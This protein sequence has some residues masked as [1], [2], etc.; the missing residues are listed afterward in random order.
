MLSWLKYVLVSVAV[1][2]LVIFSGYMTT[3]HTANTR[4]VAEVDGAIKTALLG[5]SRG[6]GLES[7]ISK[8]EFVSAVIASVVETQKNHGKTVKIDYVFLDSSGS[9]TEVDESVKS[10]QYVIEIVG[11]DGKVQSKAEKHLAIDLVAG[12]GGGNEGDNSIKT[13]TVVFEPGTE[14]RSK[15]VDVPEGVINSVTVDNGSVSH[16]VSGDKLT[17]NVTDGMGKLVSG[18]LVQGGQKYIQGHPTE[19]YEDSD[20]YKGNLERYK[21]DGVDG[22]SDTKYVTNQSGSQYKDSEGYE[23]VLSKY[24]HSGEYLLTQSKSVSET[25]TSNTSTMQGTINYSSGGFTGTLTGGNVTSR[26]VED[27]GEYKETGYW[28]SEEQYVRKGR[29]CKTH[30]W[31][32]HTNDE[33]ICIEY[34]PDIYVWEWV[35]VWVSTG[36]QW[37][38]NYKTVYSR[39]YNGVTT[40]QTPKDTRIYRYQGMV[41]KNITETSKYA[42]RG[43]VTKT[44]QDDRVYE[45]TYMVTIKYK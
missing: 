3:Q 23:G 43:Y 40:S 14:N 24:V 26:Q 4:A 36:E 19:K 2:G 15:N 16:T 30:D 37:V 33:M 9:A 11:E 17:L 45:Y 27:G 31:G 21:V 35:D 6:L 39:T 1:V 44:L 13:M 18:K 25:R 5:E 38:P 7:G 42:Y 20:G 29:G 10:I 22:F 8:E 28:D 32:S 41:T 12:L 34:H